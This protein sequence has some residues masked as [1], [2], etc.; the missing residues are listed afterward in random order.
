[1]A[2]NK[3]GLY[4]SSVGMGPLNTAVYKNTSDTLDTIKT[5]DY[6]PQET[7]LAIDDKIYIV[8]SDGREDVYVSGVDPIEVSSIMSTGPATIT[9]SFVGTTTAT[10]SQTFSIPGVLGTD[11]A[12]AMLQTPSSNEI[13]SVLTSTDEVTVYY[14]GTIPSGKTIFI[15]VF[16]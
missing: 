14:E 3:A 2:F 6:F 16:R 10:S 11:K 15:I 9:H 5:A 8:G 7:K 4:L 13:E 12:L 1:M